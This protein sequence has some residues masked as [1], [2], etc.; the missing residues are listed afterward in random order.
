MIDEKY[1]I[2]TL[3][4]IVGAGNVVTAPQDLE[5]YAR[6]GSFVKP[7][8]PLCAARP[9]DTE[10]VQ[11]I[12]RLANRES[13]ALFPFSSGTTYQGAHIPTERGITVDLRRMNNIDLLDDIARNAMRTQMRTSP[14]PSSTPTTPT[15]K[16]TPSSTTLSG[17]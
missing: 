13:V 4:E 16:N 5:Q 17:S 2:E 15:G 12:V 8:K 1:I 10:E 7:M 3:Q 14:T 9:A 6:D 11:A